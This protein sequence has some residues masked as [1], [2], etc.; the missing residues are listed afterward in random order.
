M[1][2]GKFVGLNTHVKKDENLKV[3][4]LSTYLEN[5]KIKKVNC[6]RGVAQM[7]FSYTDVY[8]VI[9]L[10]RYLTKY[11]KIEH[12]LTTSWFR[13]SIYPY[14]ITNIY[15]YTRDVYTYYKEMYKKLSVRIF[16]L[17]QN[18]ENSY[19]KLNE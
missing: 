9:T 3:N 5:L 19:Q 11:Y 18:Y 12:M 4:A 1:L 16:L 15:I 10:E 6:I 13:N 7:E 8:I 14:S 17:A 2:G